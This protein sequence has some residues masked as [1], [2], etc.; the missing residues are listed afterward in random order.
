[1]VAG[2][3]RQAAKHKAATKPILIRLRTGSIWS[4]KPRS[5][6]RSN[7]T[8]LASRSDRRARKKAKPGD[9]CSEMEQAVFR[10]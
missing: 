2:L 10:R 7:E 8:R 5:R 4:Q 3:T 6:S 1:M 9:G